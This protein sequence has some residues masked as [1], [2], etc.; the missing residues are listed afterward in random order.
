MTERPITY[1]PVRGLRVTMREEPDGTVLFIHRHEPEATAELRDRNARAS[2]ENAMRGRFIG[3]TQT[4]GHRVAE[5]PLTVVMGLKMAGIWDDE[6][7]MRRW[8]SDPDNRHFR[9]DRG[10]RL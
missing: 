3:N 1:D 2:S 5:L 8:L 4:M 6:A 9:T 10:E 7:A